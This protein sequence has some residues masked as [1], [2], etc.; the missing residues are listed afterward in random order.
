MFRA[1]KRSQEIVADALGRL[2]QR[3]EEGACQK[4][5]ARTREKNENNIMHKGNP[6]KDDTACIV[7]V[8]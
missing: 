1:L 6:K 4:P 8:V 5:N 2:C 7:R 3:D